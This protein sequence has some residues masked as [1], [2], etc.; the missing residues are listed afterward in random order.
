MKRFLLMIAV[1]VLAPS[2]AGAQTSTTDGVVA[3]IRG[4]YATAASILEPL[5]EDT[6]HP[7][8]LAAFFMASLYSFGQGVPFDALRACGLYLRAATPP[9]LVAPLGN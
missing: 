6:A 4:D 3:M 8:P 5:A 1:V 9:N 7:D 2:F